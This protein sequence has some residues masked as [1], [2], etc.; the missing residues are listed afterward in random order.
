MQHIISFLGII[1][2][3]L[4]VACQQDTQQ[5]QQVAPLKVTAQ[6]LTVQTQ[7]PIYSY[8][9]T[10]K[11]PVSIPLSVPS[12]GTIT[13]IKVK[14]GDVVKAHQLLLQTDTTQAYNAL[15]IAQATLTH[16]QDGY[17]RARQVY[18]QGGVTEQKMVEL[19]SQLQ[20]A[21][22][23]YQLA[24]KRL[25]ECTLRAPQSGVIGNINLQVGQTIAPAL[26]VVTLLNI[27]NY[28]VTFDVSESDIAQLQIGD[29]GHM[30]VS[31]L[32]QDTLPLHI[33]EKKLVPNNVAHTYTV[34][35]SLEPLPQN[36]QRKLLPGM[37]GNVYLQAQMVQ[38]MVIPAHCIQ[39]Q[40]KG[41]TVWVIQQ[42]KAQRK[43]VQVGGYTASGVLITDGLTVGDSVITAGYQKL[44]HQAN[45]VVQ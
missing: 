4:L 2:S 6:A 27:D 35:A 24:K 3:L 25:N 39:T 44:Y 15:Q 33:V 37:V 12:G 8:V 17:Q 43:A 9:G 26:P 45:V 10:I 20:Q 42:G 28:H 14:N 7:A 13:Q 19:N 22:A 34:T 38:G 21:T 31:V 23:M 18:Q 11:E 41:T 40:Q 36:T 1:L 29:K 30:V 16:A 32:P 5:K